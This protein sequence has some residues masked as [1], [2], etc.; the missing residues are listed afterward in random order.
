[1]FNLIRKYGYINFV[2]QSAD[3][4]IK[5]QY[6]IVKIN[7]AVYQFFDQKQ[8]LRSASKKLSVSPNFLSIK[9]HH[10]ALKPIIMHFG[11]Y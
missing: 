11:L 8:I 4:C 6:A 9:L 2:L 1:R 7:I 5:I 3:Y 10:N